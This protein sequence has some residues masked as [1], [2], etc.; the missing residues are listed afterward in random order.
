M[1][2]V[3]LFEQQ[4][5]KERKI[6]LPKKKSCLHGDSYKG[7]YIIYNFSSNFNFL[8]EKMLG[9]HSL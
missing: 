6:K 1:E 9:Y 3:E 5:N 8:K 4:K 2:N 7:M